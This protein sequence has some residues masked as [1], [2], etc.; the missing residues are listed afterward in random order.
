MMDEMQKTLARR[1]AKANLLFVCL[2]F[3][4]IFGMVIVVAFHDHEHV[5][6][7]LGGN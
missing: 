6:V 3:E 7:V 4:I 2:R 5:G 1:R